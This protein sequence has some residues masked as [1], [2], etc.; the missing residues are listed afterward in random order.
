MCLAENLQLY[1]V[2]DECGQSGLKYSE[3]LTNICN[4]ELQ[5]NEFDLLSKNI[6]ASCQNSCKEYLNFKETIVLNAEFQLKS[7]E[8]ELNDDNEHYEEIILNELDVDA[9]HQEEV[10]TTIVEFDTKKHN[11]TLLNGIN[12][13]TF[14]GF[15]TASSEDEN[16][17][18]PCTKCDMLF[19]T[20]RKLT[21]HLE[22]HST[23]LRLF[24]CS[25]C[26]RKFQTEMQ[27]HKHDVIHSDLITQ[28]KEEDEFECIV[29]KEVV[30]VKEELDEHMREHKVNIE[31]EPIQCMYCDKSFDKFVTLT[32]HLKKHDENKTHLCKVCNKTFALGPELIEHLN[33]HQGKRPHSCDICGKSYHQASKLK[34]HLE[35]HLEEKVSVDV[36]LRNSLS[37]VSFSGLFVHRMWKKLWS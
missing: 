27:L 1:S 13:S 35:T 16:G 14:D 37:N 34:V 29:C 9:N 20:R 5:I 31:I 23:G 3:I 36:C 4:N 11:N 24:E 32:K 8:E 6:C 2:F 12:D 33:R 10:Y 25:T 17:D 15:V 7:L 30:A 21:E 26:Q 22:K 18:F 19:H 28:I